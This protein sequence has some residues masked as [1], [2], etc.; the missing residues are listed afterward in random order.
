LEPTR[1]ESFVAP[2]TIAELQISLGRGQAPAQMEGTPGPIAND[3]RGRRPVQSGCLARHDQPS[4]VNP[5]VETAGFP[6]P[7]LAPTNENPPDFSRL[8]P[9]LAH[10]LALI[11]KH[12][13][14]K[15]D[16]EGSAAAGLSLAC[17]FRST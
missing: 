12:N 9:G 6:V 10:A 5:F 16:D 14:L 11:G 3:H 15:G 4:N 7:S 8:P 1:T 2:L 17:H 13:R